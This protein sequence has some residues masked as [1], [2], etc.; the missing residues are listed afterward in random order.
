MAYCGVLDKLISI[1]D[2]EVDLSR[3]DDGV[4]VAGD[5]E[6]DADEWIT[7][8]DKLEF[9]NETALRTK[10]DILKDI[11]SLLADFDAKS[12]GDE[13]HSPAFYERCKDLVQRFRAEVEEKTFPEKLEDWWR[14]E[15]NVRESGIVLT[16]NHIDSLDIW[17]DDTASEIIDTE[18]RLLSLK[19]RLLTVEQYAQI[20]G[21]TTTTVRQWIR[22]GK[23]RNAIKTGSEWRIPE[24]AE[25]MQRGYRDGTY[26]RK[27]YL[28]DLPAEYAFFNEY[29]FVEMDQDSEDREKYIV[30]FWKKSKDSIL[31]LGEE[32]WQKRNSRE[33]RLSQKEREKLELYLISNPFVESSDSCIT[34][35]G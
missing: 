30:R 9:F 28:T 3:L 4:I 15:Y 26:Y 27:E 35:R 24:L 5:E 1:N 19:S 25:I 13:K 34:S 22:R 10:A 20:C 12:G 2:K 17:R 8:E 18:F 11:D 29:D 23:I 6:F 21:V 7:D 31:E 16:L 14:Y 32:E 33:I